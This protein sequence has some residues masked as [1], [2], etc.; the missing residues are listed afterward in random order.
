MRRLTVLMKQINQAVRAIKKSTY[1][2]VYASTLSIIFSGK[3]SEWTTL[4]EI[5]LGSLRPCLQ[6]LDLD[7]S[8]RQRRVLASDV[9]KSVAAVKKLLL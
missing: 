3:A 8:D 6:I 7:E 1:L 5:H 4:K 9:M 2:D